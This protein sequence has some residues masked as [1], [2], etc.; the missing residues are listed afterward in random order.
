VNYAERLIELEKEAVRIGNW[1]NV[2]SVANGTIAKFLKSE[3]NRMI[4]DV[5]HLYVRIRCDQDS[6]VQQ[7]VALQS[8]E[9]ALQKVL[10]CMT[11]LQECKEALD[12]EREIC[13]KYAKSEEGVFEPLSRKE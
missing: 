6:A 3:L 1:E 9:K 13:N 8:E 2:L 5:R 11:N 4:N 10:S 7:L 12:K